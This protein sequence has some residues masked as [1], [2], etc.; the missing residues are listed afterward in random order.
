MNKNNLKILAAIAVALVATLIAMQFGGRDSVT[1]G[2]LLYPKLKSE[3]NDISNVTVTR[4]GADGVT[5]ISKESDNWVI[6]SRDDY[7][8]SIAKLRQLLLQIADA[9]IVEQKTSNP[10]LYGQLGVQDPD[11]EGS[12]GTLLQLNG[13][14]V[15]Y[16]LVIGN[17]A[18]SGYPLAR[19]GVL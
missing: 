7:P 4:A 16:E 19:T 13:D 14:S 11:I 17:A 8:V 1:N 6:A 18:D 10:D 3:I 12:K 9:K 5:V 2:R 15:Q